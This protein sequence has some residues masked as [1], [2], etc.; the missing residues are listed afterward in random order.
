MINFEETIT[1]YSIIAQRYILREGFVFTAVTFP[2]VV[3]DAIVIKYPRDV[4][5]FSPRMA[6]SA[7]SLEEHIDFINKYKIEKAL[8]IANRID[9]ITKCPTL[10]HIRIIPADS[11]GNEFD[12]S[13]L[14]EMP[15]IKS[16]H[17]STV[18][19]FKEEFS[20]SIDYSKVAGIEDFSVSG[21][22][23]KNYNIIKTLKSLGV[24]GYNK[25]DLTD[26][27]SSSILDTLTLIQCKVKSLEG[28]QR[29]KKM[30]CLYLYYNR[31]LQD[32]TSL[33]KVK[34]TL[35]ALRIENCP[36]IDDFSVLGELENLEL[37]EL[38]G[39]N[40]LPDLSFLKTMKN[41][42]TFIFSMNVLDGNLIPCLTLSYA[43]SLKNR[44]HYNLKDA[45][46]PKGQY[47]RGNETI[48]MWRRLE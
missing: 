17:C 33:R 34:K 40:S 30:Q 9:F 11:A 5:C 43:R 44:K 26:M 25:D 4:P 41:L 24:S 46:L 12:Y 3:Y 28:L 42:K 19:G 16:L 22:G 14:Y 21:L 7:H 36:K 47:V 29:S 10:K 1:D 39:N 8:I 20:T 15:E 31:S 38:S 32:I 18:Y 37:L 6:G 48:E 13:P 2:G 27:F 45:D 23:H 35:R